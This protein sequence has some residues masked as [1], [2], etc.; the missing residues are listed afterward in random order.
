MKQK[1]AIALLRSDI[2][3]KKF[4]T[5][6]ERAALF[7][8]YGGG[9]RAKQALRAAEKSGVAKAA[10][11]FHR[12]TRVFFS[13]EFPD[14]GS[15]AGLDSMQDVMSVLGDKVQAKEPNDRVFVYD[16]SCGNLMFDCEPDS[17]RAY[18]EL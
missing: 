8:L 3:N 10:I 16:I 17:G 1:I 6:Y 11:Y 13:V 7:L 12:E 18:E 4:G 9:A 2:K 5:P 15:T 14:G